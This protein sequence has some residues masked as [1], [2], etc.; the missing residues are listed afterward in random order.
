VPVCLNQYKWVIRA[1]AKYVIKYTTSIL[2][3]AFATGL[4][5][6]LW[7]YLAPAQFILYYPVIVLAALYG[8]GVSAI[9]LSAMVSQY[10]FVPPYDSFRVAWPE[11]VARQAFF[12]LSAFMIRQLTVRLSR[13]LARA[14]TQF[15]IAQRAEARI[16]I[17]LAS[18]GDAV[19]T[20]DNQGRVIFLNPVAEALTGWTFADAHGRPSSEIFRIHNQQTGESVV[21]PV[22]TVLRTG[23]TVA[24]ANHTV[25]ISRQGKRIPIEDSAAPI[26][27]GIDPLAQGVVLVFRDVSGKY[28]QE[29]LN[30]EHLLHLEQSEAKL[31]NVLDSALDAVVEMDNQGLIARWSPQAERVFGFTQAEAV[32][33]RMSETIVPQRYRLAHEAGM[34]HYLATGEGPVLNK[35]IEIFAVTKEAREIPVELSIT[36]IRAGK[37]VSFCAFLRDISERKAA[38]IERAS[39]MGELTE[40]V[41]TRDE[42]IAIASHELKTPISSLRL[43]FQMAARQ[44]EKQD[45]RVY[46]PEAVNKRVGSVNRQLERMARLIDQM[47]DASRV[48]AGKLE[49]SIER[50]DL[51]ALVVEVVSEFRERFA[52]AGCILDARVAPQLVG[53]FDGYR[54]EQVLANLLTNAMKYG[55]GS[56]VTVTLER[57]HECARLT[58]EDRGPGIEPGSL[59]RIFNQ[60]ERASSGSKIGGLGLGLYIS[61]D[62]VEAHQGTIRVESELG[63]GSI[64][65]LEL[66]LKQS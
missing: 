61:R 3:V 2:L 16:A 38:E 20:T 28:E 59:E 44:L 54:I 63:K 43:Q 14:Q 52:I 60:Y 65:V 55:E 49:L 24:L 19:V 46:S 51:S 47:F 10:F 17:T 42:F 5:L 11:G 58:V 40:A 33:K 30:A 53:N 62:I 66:P 1:V 35:R 13:A 9:A 8:D 57:A 64:F 7:R 36:P 27:A 37:E 21:S 26:R 45:V 41:R 39:L 29:L 25:L 6:L 31:R 4:Q 23:N 50:T 32:G 22:E 12:V 56:P 15:Q 18:I 34:R 48:T